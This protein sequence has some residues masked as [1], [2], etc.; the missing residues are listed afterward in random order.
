[1][2]PQTTF[3]RS[4][5]HFKA[6]LSIGFGLLLCVLLRPLG[7]L[8]QT[9]FTSSDQSADGVR[10][11]PTPGGHDYQHL[12]SETVSFGNGQLSYRVQ[13]PMP[14]GRGISMPY[15]YGYSS[16]GLYRMLL[17][18]PQNSLTWTLN[19][20]NFNGSGPFATWQVTENTQ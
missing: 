9:S 2:A 6:A 19:D 8:A 13:Y 11:M 15:W 20:L 1:M 10:M 12:L 7:A 16:A 14:K 3:C 18:M 17:Q 5:R 4:P